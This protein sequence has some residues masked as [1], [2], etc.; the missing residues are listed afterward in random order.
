M[1]LETLLKDPCSGVRRMRVTRAAAKKTLTV[2]LLIN[3]RIY[4]LKY[5]RSVT[6][7]NSR[8]CS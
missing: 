8:T 2:G 4:I 5:Q 7:I 3:L 1:S 6:A